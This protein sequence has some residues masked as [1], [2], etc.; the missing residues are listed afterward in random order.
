M[1]NMNSFKAV[2]RAIESEAARQI[3]I[4]ESGG[5]V[6]Q[7]S[8]LWNEATGSTITM[9]SKEEAHDYR[10]FPEPDLRPLSIAVDW[11]NTIQKDLP[12]LP[13]ERFAKMVRNYGLSEYDAGILVEFKELGDFFEAATAHT[14][15]YKA[16]TN[17]L[18][19]DVTGYLKSSKKN[20]ED[21]KLAP[22]AL[23]EMITLVDKNTISSAIAKKLL[24]ELLENGSD[25]EKLVAEKGLAQITDEGA[26]RKMIQDV[27]AANPK[28][29]E[30]YRAGKDKLFGFFV[31][32]VMKTTKGSANP[33][34]I[35]TLLKEELG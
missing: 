26:I 20:L 31:G 35:N 23:A 2:Q 33:E 11:V 4:I 24:P 8:R 28:Q 16:L 15:N 25:P 14:H 7:E 32:Q 19:G 13:H 12:E 6:I 29:T 9:R 34:M 18:M 10:Y 22:K 21:T 5:R 1:K 30:D 17:W 3:E 27:I